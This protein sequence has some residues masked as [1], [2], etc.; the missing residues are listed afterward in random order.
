MGEWLAH[1]LQCTKCSVIRIS[2][3]HKKAK[4]S[5]YKLHDQTVADE[6]ASKY[7]GAP[8]SNT[9]SWNKYEENVAA[10]R[11]MPL[12]FVKRKLREC[13]IP[14][15]TAS[16]TT[17]VRP[18]LMPHRCG[19]QPPNPTYKPWN[20]SRTELPDSFLTAT[21][22]EHLAVWPRYRTIWDGT[23]YRKGDKQTLHDAQNWSSSCRCGKG[24][25][26]T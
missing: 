15:K 19:I 3:K 4:E 2:P 9:L 16:Y 1:E 26:P 14:V 22:Q 7:L 8:L 18:V 5:T 20:K 17:L 11:N 13:S 10:K 25:V 23:H 6:E 12:G 21:Q 24:E